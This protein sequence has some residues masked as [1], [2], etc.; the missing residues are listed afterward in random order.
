M[1]RLSVNCALL[2]IIMLI[3]FVPNS[4]SEPYS[5][6]V[7]VSSTKPSYTINEN[8]EISGIVTNSD[9]LPVVDAAVKITT[10]K[11]IVWRNTDESG[12]FDFEE[13]KTITRGF[14]VVNILVT[15]NDDSGIATVVYEVNGGHQ[16]AK[17]VEQVQT[18]TQN[19]TINDPV[20]SVLTLQAEKILKQIAEEEQKQKE[21]ASQQK[22]LEEKR[23]LADESLLKDLERWDNDKLQY[24]P[25][26]AFASF[27]SHVDE[28]VH[29]IFWAQFNLTKKIS[30][31]AH[32]AKLKAIEDGLSRE[33]VL[34][35]FQ[36]KAA[37]S[38]DQIIAHNN[39][40]QIDAGISD[41]QIQ[42][43]FDNKG[44]LPR[45]D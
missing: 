17:P 5:L 7:S 14:Y 6:I 11:G 15:K 41:K 30:D 26:N 21:F 12:K 32:Q 35:V 36:N 38:R 22:N 16:E 1:K 43:K 44:K 31:E 4:H 25:Q 27:L 2:A 34:K 8:P 18:Y 39:Q 28:G 29:A 13:S 33:D 40:I 37:I 24:A 10:S 19:N 42:E 23:R 45:T 9:G 3:S 20:A